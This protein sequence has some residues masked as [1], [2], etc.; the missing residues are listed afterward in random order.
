[1]A[2]QRARAQFHLWQKDTSPQSPAKTKISVVSPRTKE[3]KV[4][5]QPWEEVRH[6]AGARHTLRARLR[7]SSG[8]GTDSVCGTPSG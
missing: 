3:S 6:P 2:G 1:M 8:S 4:D 7:K 5:A